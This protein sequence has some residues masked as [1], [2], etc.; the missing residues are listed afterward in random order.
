MP[1]LDYF[2]ARYFLGPQGRFTIE[3]LRPD[4]LFLDIELPGFR[5]RW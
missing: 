5:C 3:E 2:G 1:G 4:L